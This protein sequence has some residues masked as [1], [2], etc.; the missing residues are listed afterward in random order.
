MTGQATARA[1]TLT[2]PSAR[3]PRRFQSCA[4]VDVRSGRRLR[5]FLVGPR[6]GCTVVFIDVCSRRRRHAQ[7]ANEPDR[8]RPGPRS[9]LG[10]VFRAARRRRFLCAPASCRLVVR[11]PAGYWH[12][13]GQTGTARGDTVG[14]TPPGGL[15][16]AVRASR[17]AGARPRFASSSFQA[18]QVVPSI[19]SIKRDASRPH[20]AGI[21]GFGHVVA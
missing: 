18:C 6:P 10:L 9:L 14:F 11:A 21:V 8:R 12:V 17:T 13:F 20:A 1:P 2:P 15:W 4:L 5:R 19:S 7:Q 3:P 16:P